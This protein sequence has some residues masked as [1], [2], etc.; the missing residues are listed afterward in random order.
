MEKFM[1]LIK[2]FGKLLIIILGF[3]YGAIF[4]V[5]AIGAGAIKG[6]FMPVLANLILMTV[7]T[8]AIISVPLLLLLKKETPAR[9]IFAVLAIYW[10]I[11][12]AQDNLSLAG[13]AVK[14][15]PGE[16]VTAGIFAFIIAL[17]L[18][19]V[20]VL[21][22]VYYVFNRTPKVSGKVLFIVVLAVLG[23]IIVFSM[24][25]GI[26]LAIAYSGDGGNWPFV[27]DAIAEGFIVPPLVIVGYLYF[28]MDYQAPAYEEVPVEEHGPDSFGDAEV[29]ESEQE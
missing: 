27:V 20:S 18:L 16:A 10:M 7:G 2:K 9:L 25:K 28:F 23:S 1:S 13:Y 24:V 17:L 15:M 29:I 8:G 21:L 22:I 6:Q 3:A 11:Y 19:A 4:A 14:G 5:T 26:L 12:A